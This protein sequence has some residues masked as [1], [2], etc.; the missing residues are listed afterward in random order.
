MGDRLQIRTLFSYVGEHTFR[1]SGRYGIR[2]GEAAQSGGRAELKAPL[3][4]GL[5]LI[6]FNFKLQRVQ[7]AH[8]SG[9][10]VARG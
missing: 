2:M 9:M 10:P 7:R 4:R 1:L 8:A 3:H 6:R 5:S